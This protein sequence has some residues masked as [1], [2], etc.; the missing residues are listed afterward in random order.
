MSGAR[1]VRAPPRLLARPPGAFP[2]PPSR[3]SH[4]APA[5]PTAHRTTPHTPP[6]QEWYDIK[7]PSMFTHRVSGKTPVT[8]TSGTHVASESL[9]G[10]VFTVSLADL[11]GSEDLD[12]RKIKLVG[13]EVQ[14]K[15]LL[16]SFYG[17]DMTRD[18]LASLMRKWQT[19]IEASAEAKTTDGYTLRLFAIAFTKRRPNQVR[20]TSYASSA[21]IRAIRKKMIEIMTAE[22]VKSNL[23]QLVQ[24]F[25][26]EA[27]SKEIE[28]SCASIYP[29]QVRAGGGGG[30]AGG[31]ANLSSPPRFP[32][33]RAALMPPPKKK[34]P[35]PA[36][37]VFIRK[38][39]TIKS[40]R[41]DIVRL[42][43]QH[44]SSNAGEDG[45][46]GVKAE[47]PIV[48]SLEGAGGR[49]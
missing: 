8:R 35:L 1:G 24:K 33:T 2:R 20:K 31:E 39:K 45:G 49:L 15:Q 30:G 38:V 46:K 22:V 13:E 9:K 44:E 41:F 5:P 29:L 7:A 26:P 37:N 11:A 25:V 42:M 17:M 6:P 23:G 16:T 36:Q 47:A 3:L 4:A 19:L 43:E 48:E 28:K 34:I 21:Q 12:Y 18:K 10:R 27:I 14:G 32:T 40:P